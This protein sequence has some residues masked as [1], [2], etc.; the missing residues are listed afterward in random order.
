[1]P[2]GHHEVLFPDVIAAGATGGSAAAGL[3]PMGEGA[4]AGA[5][6]AAGGLMGMGALGGALNPVV[7]R[8]AGEGDT[9]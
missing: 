7:L 8:R 3:T 9:P 4:A 1:M 2:A 5:A 6:G